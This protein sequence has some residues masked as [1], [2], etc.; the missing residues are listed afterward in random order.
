M[1]KRLNQFRSGRALCSL[2][3]FVVVALGLA[4]GQTAA[5][6]KGL[7]KGMLDQGEELEKRGDLDQALALYV[8]VGR[9]VRGIPRKPTLIS[10]QSKLKMANR[11]LDEA[12]KLYATGSYNDAL[13]RVG[14]AESLVRESPRVFFNYAACHY[15]LGDR[16]KALE[17]LAHAESLLDSKSPERV[18]LAQLRSVV[19]TG[20]TVGDIPAESRERP[21]PL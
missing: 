3:I 2:G 8:Q 6:P 18:R 7:A 5:D 16:E 19:S 4:S 12:A 14:L 10:R 1:R 15:K 17:D 11:Y 13:A 21:F 9:V 20:E